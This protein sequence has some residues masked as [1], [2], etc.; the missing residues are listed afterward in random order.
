MGDEAMEAQTARQAQALR[1]AGC[2]PQLT[3]QLLCCWQ[4]G[5]TAGELRL[6]EKQRA[7]LLE[8]I[9]KKERQIACLDYLVHQI[10]ANKPI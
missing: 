1:A 5:D 6:L 7:L 8:Q 4:Q 2:G 10:R 3:G 9:H